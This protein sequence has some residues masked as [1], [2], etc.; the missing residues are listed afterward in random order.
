M[1]KV[2]VCRE[3]AEIQQLMTLHDNVSSLPKTSVEVPRLIDQLFYTCLVMFLRS[4]YCYLSA[5][6]PSLAGS[7]LNQHTSTVVKALKLQT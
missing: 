6:E 2:C 7:E 1:D 5:V 4:M 3:E